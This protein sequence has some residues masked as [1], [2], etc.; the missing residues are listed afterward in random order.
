MAQKAKVKG[1]KMIAFVLWLVESMT[2]I[3]R[4]WKTM[5]D[6]ILVDI[7]LFVLRRK[8]GSG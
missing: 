6:E 2:S 4:R 3:V 1:Q 8:W 7:G 5:T